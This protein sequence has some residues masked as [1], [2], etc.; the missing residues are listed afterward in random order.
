MKQAKLLLWKCRILQKLILDTHSEAIISIAHDLYILTQDLILSPSQTLLMHSMQS[1]FSKVSNHIFLNIC[2]LG[3]V[4]FPL[5]LKV[6]E[7][8]PASPHIPYWSLQ[9]RQKLNRQH[10]PASL[11]LVS[12]SLLTPCMH[13][14]K[15]HKLLRSSTL[16]HLFCDEDV[17]PR[18][19]K[20]RQNWMKFSTAI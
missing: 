5:R 18:F 17:H 11:S 7:S 2:L 12:N 15:H 3:F 8:M 14:S 9:W 20:G 13:H 6:G 10:S 19:P 4:L 16:Q 1:F